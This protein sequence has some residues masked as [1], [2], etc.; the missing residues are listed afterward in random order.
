M[1]ALPCAC[2]SVMSSSIFDTLSSLLSNSEN[3]LIKAIVKNCHCS[4]FQS[5]KVNAVN[6][7]DR[8]VFLSSRKRFTYEF[9]ENAGFQINIKDYR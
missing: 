3:T 6:I 9:V 8:R 2:E 7:E 1:H 5:L 4:A